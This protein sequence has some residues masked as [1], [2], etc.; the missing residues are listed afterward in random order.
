MPT[1]KDKVDA[2]HGTKIV[3]KIVMTKEEITAPLN[4]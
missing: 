1:H 2:N 3:R 4:K